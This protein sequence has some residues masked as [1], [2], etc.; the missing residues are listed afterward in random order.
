MKLFGSSR[1]VQRRFDELVREIAAKEESSLRFKAKALAVSEIA[2]QYYCEKKVELNRIHGEEETFEMRLGKEG[3]EL[4]LKDAT[5]IK[6]RELLCKIFSGEPV[7]VREMLLLGK[8]GSTI[9]AGVPDIV[10]FHRGL[11]IFLFEHKFP[12]RQI[13]FRHHH[14]QARL[15]CYL[16]QLMGWETKKLKYVLVIAPPEC[17]GDKDLRRIPSYVLRQPSETRLKVKLQAGDANLYLNDYDATEA[18]DELKWA[19]GFWAGERPAMPTTKKGKCRSC[20]F[21]KICDYSLASHL[22]TLDRH[23][24][25]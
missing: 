17:R 22:D 20:R 9:V 11:P 3:H 23:A 7:M 18:I 5:R 12:S 15:Y 21:S 10:L 16:L 14:V 8:H 6:R 24:R 25:R 1:I 4:L 19:L 2:N 13:P